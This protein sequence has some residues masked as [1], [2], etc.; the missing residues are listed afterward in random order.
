MLEGRKVNTILGLGQK[1]T[2]L[3]TLCEYKLP[4]ILIFDRDIKDLLD[5]KERI[6]QMSGHNLCT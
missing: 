3:L 5:V 4:L 2:L 1:C 6:Y